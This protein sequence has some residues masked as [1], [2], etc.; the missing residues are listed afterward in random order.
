LTYTPILTPDKV[1]LIAKVTAAGGESTLTLSSLNLLPGK[2][3]IFRDR[4]KSKTG[5]ASIYFNND[6]TP[7][8]YKEKSAYII[9][10]GTSLSVNSDNNAPYL[11]GPPSDDVC[12]EFVGD[13]YF[14]VENHAGVGGFVVANLSDYSGV[15][16]EMKHVLKTDA[17]VTS[18]TRIDLTTNATGG[19]A[20]GSFIAV[21]ETER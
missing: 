18:I 10:G 11:H 1:G 15:V 8:H 3:Y 19:F 13:L 20:A 14:N 17:A 4:I 6:T 16:W 9:T 2:R 5:L 21:Y 7:G 12:E